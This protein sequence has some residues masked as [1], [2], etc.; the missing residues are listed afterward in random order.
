[1]EHPLILAKGRSIVGKGV[2]RKLRAMGFVPAVLYGG[3]GETRGLVVNSKAVT[4]VLKGKGGRNSVVRLSIDDGK[5]FEETIAIVREFQV[6]P[7]KRT[8][9]HCDFMRVDDNTE[10]KVRVPVRITG[11]AEGEKLGAKLNLAVRQANLLCK[12]GSVPDEIVVDVTNFKVGQVMTLSQLPL[13]QG[14]RAVF[15]KDNAVVTLRM[16]RA[17]KGAAGEEAEDAAE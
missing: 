1:M 11:K 5:A 3:E 6:H 9:L 13:P 17:E 15:V 10:I 16:P 2:A 4:D 7:L 12:A 8:L 14:A